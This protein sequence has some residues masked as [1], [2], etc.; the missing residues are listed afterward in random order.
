MESRFL[1]PVKG[2]VLLV[3]NSCERVEGGVVVIRDKASPYMDFTV[4]RTS[5]SDDL[6]FGQG[7]R[8]VLDDPY[9]GRQVILDGAPY[10]LVPVEHIVAVMED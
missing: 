4:A 8:V 7:D 2:Q 6:G 10:R 3:E 5:P 1:H 9:A